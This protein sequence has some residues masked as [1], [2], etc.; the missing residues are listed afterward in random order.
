MLCSKRKHWAKVGPGRRPFAE[1]SRLINSFWISFCR[2]FEGRQTL[3]EFSHSQRSMSGGVDWTKIGSQFA[4]HFIKCLD[5]KKYGELSKFL[6]KGTI[7][8]FEGNNCQG[9]EQIIK[10]LQAFNK[11]YPNT[12][13]KVSV[14]VVPISGDTALLFIS[15]KRRDNKHR[16]IEEAVCVSSSI[17]LTKT[18][19][20][21]SVT[22]WLYRG[23][24][25]SANIPSKEL[26][27]GGKLT[28]Q[29]YKLYDENMKQLR[30]V[31]N[32]DTR[33]K[34]ERDEL[35]GADMIMCKLTPGASDHVEET[36]KV[37]LGFR[38]VR[39]KSVKHD[40]Q[41]MDVHPIKNVLLIQV[42]GMLAPD[43]SDQPVHFGEVFL[44]SKVKDGWKVML[45]VFRQIY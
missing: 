23:E 6:G 42:G 5:G 29:F 28:E 12:E 8:S 39:F 30:P 19:G 17:I 37:K 33:M 27:I 31:Y 15:G 2:Q 38:S 16:K 26:E 41:Q 10:L 34:Y 18:K 4:Q 11:S 13:H 24:K 35:K 25:K 7:A 3:S 9:A 21:F 45:Q 40:L 1:I 36:K 32:N 22:N 20:G 14:D 43:G 44:W